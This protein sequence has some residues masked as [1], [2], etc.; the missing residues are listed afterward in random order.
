MAVVLLIAFAP[1]ALFMEHWVAA[2]AEPIV[3]QREA[4]SH[5]HHQGGGTA[6]A[7][8]AEPGGASQPTHCHVG[9]ES[10]AVSSGLSTAVIIAAVLA[11]TL[12]G[13]GT[14]LLDTRSAQISLFDLARRLVVPPRVNLRSV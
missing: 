10:C 13:G 7:P 8:E 2:A 14:I 6:A 11:L 4:D 9:P 12:L 3:E 1:N 5:A